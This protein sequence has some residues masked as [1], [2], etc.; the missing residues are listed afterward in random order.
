[1]GLTLHTGQ[2]LTGFMLSV[3]VKISVLPEKRQFTFNDFEQPL[4]A[5]TTSVTVAA[6]IRAFVEAIAGIIFFTTP[7]VKLYVTPWILNLS[8]LSLAFSQIH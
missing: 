7:R 4:R 1:M 2:L 6:E 3:L 8:A 5:F